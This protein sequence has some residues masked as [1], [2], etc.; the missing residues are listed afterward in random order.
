MLEEEPALFLYYV[1]FYRKANQPKDKSLWDSVK[2]KG[3]SSGKIVDKIL[4]LSLF[5]FSL[6]LAY[7]SKYGYYIQ[8]KEEKK[9]QDSWFFS[10]LC[11]KGR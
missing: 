4:K 7:T 1:I 10:S 5:D 9:E 8:K 11:D 2:K 3:I 6:P